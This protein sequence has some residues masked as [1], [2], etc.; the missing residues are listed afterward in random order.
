MEICFEFC[1]FISAG[2]IKE[3]AA[4]A[5]NGFLVKEVLV[6][7]AEFCNSE[8]FVESLLG[9]G[10]SLGTNLMLFLCCELAYAAW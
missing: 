2:T 3:K 10:E 1:S 5:V 4:N 9:N 6:E 7:S 8:R